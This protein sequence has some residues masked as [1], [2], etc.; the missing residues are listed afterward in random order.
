MLVVVSPDSKVT[1]NREALVD[2]RTW[3]ASERELNDESSLRV[4]TPGLHGGK[5][6]SARRS[7]A[8]ATVAW[9][10]EASPGSSGAGVTGVDATCTQPA[11]RCRARPSTGF[12]VPDALMNP[13]PSSGQ[14][15]CDRF[16]AEMMFRTVF[17]V[18]ADAAVTPCAT[19]AHA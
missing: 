15:D 3:L 7:N 19:A 8:F 1:R 13:T 14:L 6:R 17:A 12:A 2:A 9:T 4:D 11:W 10:V 18:P 5:R 16:A